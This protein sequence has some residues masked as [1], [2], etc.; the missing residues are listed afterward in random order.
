LA[1]HITATEWF[2]L[3]QSIWMSIRPKY[4][5]G[6]IADFIHPIIMKELVFIKDIA[7]GAVFFAV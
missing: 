2:K 3:W 1:G 7:A 4:G 5:C 6:K